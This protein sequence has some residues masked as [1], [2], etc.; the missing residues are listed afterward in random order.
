MTLVELVVVIVI[1]GIVA[2]I[3]SSFIVTAVTGYS[4]L[5]RR[6]EL[7]D[8]A[9]MSLRR[10]ARDVRRA[11]PNSVR[12][13][14]AA[15]NL[16]A[17]TVTCTT[18]GSHCAIELLN[19]LDGAR[20]REG[21]G[22]VPGGHAH[23]SPQYRLNTSATDT[24]FNIVGFFQQLT[25]PFTS[26][27]GSKGERIAVYNLGVSGADA[28]ADSQLA[29]TESY[30]ITNPNVTAFQ[31]SG[32]GGGDEHQFTA[33]VGNFYFRYASPTQRV[34]IV[35]TPVTYLCSPGS[36]GTITRYWNYPV[37]PAQPTS[38]T[39]TR[40]ASNAS[41]Q[42]LTKP[43]TACT[44]AYQPGTDERAGLITLD[45]TVGDADTEERIRLLY[46]AHVDNAP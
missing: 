10:L 21:P 34:F 33:T 5:A 46:Q 13:A 31:V 18:A 26:T 17:G 36:A 6:G 2:V 38:P 1:A 35:D 30:V 37:G 15:G 40:L 23:G 43:V 29:A 12:V 25:V 4:D 7:V 14:D 28:Y 16:S 19:T 27:S 41:S 44:F 11:L 9:E 20:Y 22:T 45:I 39:D 32:D 3:S 24:S 8:A 42:L